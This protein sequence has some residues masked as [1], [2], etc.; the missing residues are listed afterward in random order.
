MK[1]VQ[2]PLDPHGCVDQ[3]EIGTA[4]PE[5]LTAARRSPRG[6]KHGG[7]ITLGH[8]HGER[9]HLFDRRDA[10]LGDPICA[11]APDPAEALDDQIVLHRGLEN[12]SQERVGGSGQTRRLRGRFAHHVPYSDRKRGR[13]EREHAPTGSR[14][15][16]SIP[17]ELQL[18][19]PI[20]TANL[21]APIRNA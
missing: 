9:R 7:P 15:R 4:E 20:L 8:C 11:S 12:G 6:D 18:A 13:D 1:L 10:P 16:S 21:S 14:R 2:R 5:D 17:K 3:I 19:I